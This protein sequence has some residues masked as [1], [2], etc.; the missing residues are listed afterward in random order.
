M[1]KYDNFQVTKSV[2]HEPRDLASV[3]FDIKV[4][5]EI[6]KEVGAT[7]NDVF[8]TLISAAMDKL[9]RA[10]VKE[11]GQVSL[12]HWS[13][14]DDLPKYR[15]HGVVIVNLRPPLSP[16]EIE[17][18]RK[19]E[20][21]PKWGTVA[22]YVIAK[23]PVNHVAGPLSRLLNVKTEMDRLKHSAE[24]T[25][26]KSGMDVIHTLFGPQVELMTS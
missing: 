23:M 11:G 1:L 18:M 20:E 10:Q 19:G 14:S 26:S 22:G 4:L 2:R 17:S 8:V 3:K 13:E 9:L 24:A 25:I 7:V 5:K 16:S 6:G 15:P 21:S 12:S